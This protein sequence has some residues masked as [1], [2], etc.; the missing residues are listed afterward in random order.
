ML[1]HAISVKGIVAVD[2]NIIRKIASKIASL[3][4]KEVERLLKIFLK[5]TPFANHAFAVGGYN[6]DELLGLD[7][8]DLD[9][10]VDIKDGA[11]KYD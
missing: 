11:E 2:S 4:E 8:K 5:G 9:I 3:P 7:A 6:R 1:K 10:V